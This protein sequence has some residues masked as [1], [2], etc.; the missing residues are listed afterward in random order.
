MNHKNEI[1]PKLMEQLAGLQIPAARQPETAAKGRAAFLAEARALAPAVT[2]TEKVRHTLWIT[3]LQSIFKNPQKEKSPMFSALAAIVLAVTLALGGGGAA[4]AFAQSS[5]PDQP[6]YAIKLLSENART[7]LTSDTQ[8]ELQLELEFAAR[9]ASEIQQMV[10]AGNSPSLSVEARYQEQVE[11]A[12]QLAASLPDSQAIEAL[13]QIQSRLQEQQQVLMQAQAHANP[14]GQAALA[15]VNQMLQERLQWV[16]GGMSDLS[17]LRQ[18]MQNRRQGTAMPGQSNPGMGSGTPRMSGT[19]MPGNGS[20]QGPAGTMMA[21]GTPMPGGGMG[22]T[23]TAAN[24]RMQTPTTGTGSGQRMTA[25]PGTGGDMGGGMQ[26]S[27]T[28]ATS[29]GQN[30]SATPG[31]GGGMG[32]GMAPSATPGAGSGQSPSM[33][34]GMGGGMGGGRH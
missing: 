26:P 24:G 17:Q 11:Q 7:S 22:R 4:I 19:A 29:P 8:T 2:Q 34:P 16:E 21:S 13:A 10:L 14:Q 31:M 12:I 32:G 20:G 5:L 27:A 15:N 18:T 28:S 3:K 9:R 33:T 23:A 1:D 25:T 6:L 30:P